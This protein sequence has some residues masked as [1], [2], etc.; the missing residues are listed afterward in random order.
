MTEGVMIWVGNGR[1]TRTEHGTASSVM[2]QQRYIQSRR[3]RQGLRG[4]KNRSASQGPAPHLHP[5]ASQGLFTFRG[6]GKIEGIYLGWG[7]AASGHRRLPL[8][9]RWTCPLLGVD[10]P[11]QNVRDILRRKSKGWYRRRRPALRQQ[12][13][14][15]PGKTDTGDEDYDAPAGRFRLLFLSW[16]VHFSKL[17]LSQTPTKLHL[18][19]PADLLSTFRTKPVVHEPD[20]PTFGME[21]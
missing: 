13:T 21:G 7:G 3:Q 2:E 5:R 14:M 17:T 1:F 16:P 15:R 4:L 6:I 8:W 20:R 19:F 11:K 10:D 18:T 12:S 9:V